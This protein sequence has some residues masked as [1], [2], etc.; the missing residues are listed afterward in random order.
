MILR[1]DMKHYLRWFVILGH[2]WRHGRNMISDMILEHDLKMILGMI[3]DDLIHDL[4]W[5]EMLWRH[6]SVEWNWDMILDMVRDDFKHDVETW[7]DMIWDMIW[8]DFRHDSVDWNWDMI[9]GMILRNDVEALLDMIWDDLKQDVEAWF[10]IWY[11]ME[12][13]YEA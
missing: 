11:D 8:D 7:W 6:D 5:F 4:R 9:L 12:T 1:H 3:W 13:R 2:D 10:E